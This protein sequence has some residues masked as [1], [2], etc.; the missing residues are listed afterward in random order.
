[1]RSFYF[2][3]GCVDQD[4]DVLRCSEHEDLGP[5]QFWTVYF[6]E[7]DS[8]SM[9]VEDFDTEEAAKVFAA[10]QNLRLKKTGRA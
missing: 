10:E 6:V 5:A 2:V 3:E 9:A 4:G 8:P 1:M 7:E